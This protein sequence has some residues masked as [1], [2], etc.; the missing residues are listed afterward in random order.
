MDFEKQGYKFSLLDEPLQKHVV[1]WERAMR[2]QRNEEPQAILAEVVR[3]LSSIRVTDRGADI[4][5]STLQLIA[6]NITEALNVIKANESATLNS[7]RSEILKAAIKSEWLT[8]YTVEQVDELP[9]WVVQWASSEV[10]G[11]YNRTQVIPPN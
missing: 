9:S 10:A 6:R 1:A 2:D 5:Y 4:L 7:H 11:L 3:T 8:G